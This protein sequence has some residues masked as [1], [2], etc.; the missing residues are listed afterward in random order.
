MV[1]C[2]RSGGHPA[3]IDHGDNAGQVIARRLRLGRSATIFRAISRV[4]Y[5]LSPQIC[6][7][8]ARQQTPPLPNTRPHAMAMRMMVSFLS[9]YMS[10]RRSIELTASPHRLHFV[11]EASASCSGKLSGALLN[12]PH[13]RQV[14]RC[15][16]LESQDRWPF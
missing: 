11:G 1:P 15:E 8:D 16:L 10:A 2:A 5:F 13:L 7:A 3:V 12:G 14:G 9:G 4:S 6:A